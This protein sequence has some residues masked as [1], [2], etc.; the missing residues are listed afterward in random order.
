MWDGF[1]K[2]MYNISL[3]TS[4]GLKVGVVCFR[5]EIL[6]SSAILALFPK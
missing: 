2:Y 6:E 3:L 5:S 4:N 1:Q